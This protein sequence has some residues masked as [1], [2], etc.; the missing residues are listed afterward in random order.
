MSQITPK[1]FQ[2]SNQ[3]KGLGRLWFG[4]TCAYLPPHKVDTR[5][6]CL[7][8]SMM[9]LLT[10][11]KKAEIIRRESKKIRKEVQFSKI[12]PCLLGTY[13]INET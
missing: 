9:N 3:V 13:I 12:Y 6:K 10:K 1:M 11:V 7:S 2:E 8:E 5:K 4:H